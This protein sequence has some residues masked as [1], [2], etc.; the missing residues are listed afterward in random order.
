MP[1][2][3]L[4]LTPGTSQVTPPAPLLIAGTAITQQEWDQY[5][6]G[7]PEPSTVVDDSPTR[8]ADSGRQLS[9]DSSSRDA[10]DLS[11]A[12]ASSSPDTEATLCD[13]D[14][15]ETDDYIQEPAKTMVTAGPTTPSTE[16]ASPTE[17]HVAAHPPIKRRRD[18][19]DPN[20]VAERDGMR[21]KPTT[22]LKHTGCETH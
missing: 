22:A 14:M 17:D 6:P 11:Q 20:S 12:Q 4:Q 9:Y 21:L 10:E 19:N 15:A 3:S 13:T 5:F 2:F 16:P 18:E 8:D 7:P 1:S